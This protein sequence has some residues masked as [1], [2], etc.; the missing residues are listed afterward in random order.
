MKSLPCQ[1]FD[2]SKIR[3][4]AFTRR[5]GRSDDDAFID[6]HG[7][8]ATWEKSMRC[9]CI[10]KSGQPDYRCPTCFGSGWSYYDPVL[11]K[12]II[13]GISLRKQLREA[14][15][16]Q[17]GFAQGSLSARH[18]VGP[19]DRFTIESRLVITVDPMTRGTDEMDAIRYPQTAIQDI[20]SIRDANGVYLEM[21]KTSEGE[22]ADFRRFGNTIH[23]LPGARAPEEGSVYSVRFEHYPIF[24]VINPPQARGEAEEQ[25]PWKLD[26]RRLEYMRGETA[27]SGGRPG[28]TV[29]R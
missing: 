13:T 12:I 5:E 4:H 10:S 21:G 2:R 20:L 8:L 25:F 23:W 17:P 29:I 7:V 14:G 3:P 19:H 26:L 24:V 16:F 28:G 22:T 11:V 27:I 1:R 9:G 6:F 18:K 15:E